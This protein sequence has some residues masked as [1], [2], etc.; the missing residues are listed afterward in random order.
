MITTTISGTAFTA[1]PTTTI[2]RT[3]KELAQEQIPSIDKSAKT[4]KSEEISYKTTSPLENSTLVAF[5]D[6]TNDKYVILS[7]KDSTIDTLKSHFGKDDFY[8]RDDGIIRLDN[9]AESYVAGW[10]ADIAYKREFLKADSDGDGKLNQ[11][12]YANTNNSFKHSGRVEKHGNKVDKISTWINSTYVSSNNKEKNVINQFNNDNTDINIDK[13]LNLTIDKDKNFDSEISFAEALQEHY[14]KNLTDSIV[15]LADDMI[16]LHK[17]RPDISDPDLMLKL[18]KKEMEK[19]QKELAALQKLKMANGDITALNQNELK[20][21]DG[22]LP[23]DTKNINN[24][25]ID[26]I[27]KNIT[28]QMKIIKTYR[29]KD[30]ENAGKIVDL[31][32]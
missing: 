13:Q 2:D 27:S 4:Q 20:L 6:P 28:D 30:S 17:K 9:K 15:Q 25:E 7:L 31:K 5:K 1:V 19:A 8:K 16:G 26:K 22:L 32:G 12:E 11:E 14:K 10:F 29:A 18:L 23:N 24:D 21:L 3:N